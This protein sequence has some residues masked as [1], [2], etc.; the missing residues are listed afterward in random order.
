MNR[1]TKIKLVLFFL[2]AV[3]SVFVSYA[4]CQKIAKTH[5]PE[6]APYIFSGQINTVKVQEGQVA[7][8]TGALMGG[9]EYKI[10]IAGEANYTPFSFRILDK[11][12]KVLF[13][14]KEHANAQAWV[15]KVGIT[16]EYTIELGAAVKNPAK[17]NMDKICVGILVGFIPSSN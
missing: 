11:D 1:F 14:N 10:I 6:L 8:L 12:K 16:E 13:D 2:F 4:Q 15:F 7:N 3:P 5:V 9:Q 17:P